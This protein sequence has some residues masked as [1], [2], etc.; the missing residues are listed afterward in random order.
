MKLNKS[1]V[2]E[3]VLVLGGN[4]RKKRKYLGTIKCTLYIRI[5]RKTKSTT[6]NTLTPHSDRTTNCRVQPDSVDDQYG[7]D[8]YWEDHISDQDKIEYRHNFNK[9]AEQIEQSY[10][11]R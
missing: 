10:D 2:M 3:I 5:Y 9:T 6:H 1:F 4:R 11:T 8:P 7:F